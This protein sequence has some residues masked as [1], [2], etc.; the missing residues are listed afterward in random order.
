MPGPLLDRPE[1][2]LAADL[3]TMCRLVSMRRP[4]PFFVQ[5]GANDGSYND[6]FLRI[7]QR[8]N[9]RGIL[10]EPQ[11][12]VFQ[13]LEAHCSR[14]PGL[15][16]V[17]AALDRTEGQR[18]LFRVKA[19]APFSSE[20]SG[21]ASF[22]RKHLVKHDGQFPGIAEWIEGVE[23]R[24]ETFDSLLG[25]VGETD[26]DVLQVDTEG[27]DA[28][29]VA[30]AEV[31]RRRTSLVNYEHKHLKRT[32]WDR[33]VSALLDAGFKVNRSWQDTLAYRSESDGG[34]SADE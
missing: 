33:S 7:A 24:C 30:M 2:I 4:D 10:V 20:V 15:T 23:V 31:H 17:N 14:F 26:F 21:L 8:L 27:F 13:R 32:D 25:L 22:D 5:V 28:E 6:P 12:D 19:G 9:W 16:C 3:D 34:P 18:E 1:H 11:P 29:V